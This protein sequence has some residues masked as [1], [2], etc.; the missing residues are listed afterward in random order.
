MKLVQR[1]VGA[2][3]TLA[4]AAIVGAAAWWL[5]TTKPDQPKADKPPGPA[6]V[7]K[8]VKETNLNTVTLTEKAE[9]RIG[10][11]VAAVEKKDVRRA[12]VY[13]GEVTIPV[14]RA[15]PVAA[16][17]GGVLK[18]PTGGE[19]KAGQVV[20]AGDVV[21]ELTPLFT[22]DGR[23]TLAAAL[24]D[25]EGQVN[26]AKAQA[27]LA[28]VA[29]DRA[30]RVLKEGAGSQRQVD[31]ADAASS[32]AERTLA[33]ATARQSVLKKVVGYADAGTAAPIQLTA[34]EPGILRVVSARPGQTVPS[35]AALFEVIDLTTV[36][37]RVPL[38]VGDTDALDLTAAAQVGRL[39]ATAAKVPVF[40]K[41]IPAPPSA[42]SLAGTV[43]AFYEVPNAD[44]KLSPGQRLGVTISR[45]DATASR[46][47]PWSAVVF[48]VHGGTWV[49]ERVAAR[50]YARRRAA[51][52]YTVGG[53]AV[54]KDESPK[55][56]TVGAMVVT[57]GVQ[58]LWVRRPGS[59]S[60]DGAVENV[61]VETWDD[62]IGCRVGRLHRHL[63]VPDPIAGQEQGHRRKDLPDRH[64]LDVSSLDR[65]R[66][67]R[68]ECAIGLR[69][70]LI[71]LTS[72][73]LPDRPMDTV[74]IAR[75]GWI[76]VE[77]EKVNAPRE[78]GEGFVH[79]RPPRV[80]AS[81][82]AGRNDLDHGDDAIP[83]DVADDHPPLA[84]GVNLP[85]GAGHDPRPRLDG[86]DPGSTARFPI[87]NRVRTAPRRLVQC[88]NVRV[89][90]AG[91]LV[92]ERIESWRQQTAVEYPSNLGDPQQV[93]V[94]KHAVV[95]AGPVVYRHRPPSGHDCRQYTRRP[96]PR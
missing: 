41:P 56:L 10:L 26:T 2:V 6:A 53:D 87:R 24:A 72:D 69:R 36:W 15:I 29:L 59:S 77:Q 34:P 81:L 94:V 12:R 50:T 49:Y 46:T 75:G 83:A 17:L 67:I 14:G 31:E 8:V 5:V 85:V 62:R 61:A 54:L 90:A 65:P 21:F 64:W 74:R 45:T 52:A 30:K 96:A 23:A 16:P 86:E 11:T 19:L 13:G 1:I 73:R 76:Q 68:H 18:A 63:D 89:T 25:A 44:G 22:P 57:N 20:K 32:V 47:V 51:V 60:I 39:S 33:A 78:C 43:D 80:F 58:E 38:P 27:E 71:L 28:R 42:N 88:Q 92:R 9:E 91:H 35:G 84:G 3:L 70:E 55:E 79:H 37:V 48:D 93:E 4:L 40:A 66:G 95:H 7:E 82:V